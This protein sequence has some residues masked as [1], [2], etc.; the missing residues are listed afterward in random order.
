MLTEQCP[1]RNADD[2]RERDT[3]QQHGSRSPD[4]VLR[5][6][7]WQR[8]E[9]HRE[10][11]RVGERREGA[12][13]EEEREVGGEGTDD[14]HCGEEAEEGE[15]RHFARQFAA[16]HRENW[17]ADDHSRREERREQPGGTDGDTGARGDLGEK[18]GEDELG[19]ALGED[20]GG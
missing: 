13:G 11:P 16:E 15:E 1:G 2:A 9:R 7:R 17:C 12:G 8:R 18:P 19:R 10:K 4:G 6:E 14:V 5:D 20:R 3:G